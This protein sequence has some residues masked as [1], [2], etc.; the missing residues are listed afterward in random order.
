MDQKEHYVTKEKL[1]QLEAELQ[2]LKKETRREIAEKLEY[3]KSLGDL[4][5]NAEYHEARELQAELEDKIARLEEIIKSAVIV[6][7]KHSTDAAAVGS[8]VSV[9][10]K[11]DK[12]VIN[13]TLV[14]TEEADSLLGKISV[15]S[16]FGEAIIGKK[17]G[18]KFSFRTP[19]GDVEYTIVGLK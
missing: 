3:A 18:E 14:G 15:R 12:T 9:Q 13:Y 16:P 11:G 8:V 10:K 4:S 5:E 19:S 2:V 6:S 17:K 1:K 7:E